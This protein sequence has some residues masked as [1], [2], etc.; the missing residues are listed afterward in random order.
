MICEQ[1]HVYSLKFVKMY[2]LAH[3]MVNIGECFM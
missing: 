2:I 1:N 3:N